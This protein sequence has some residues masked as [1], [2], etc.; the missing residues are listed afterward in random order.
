[1]KIGRKLIIVV[2]AVMTVFTSLVLLQ[3]Y[4]EIE[5]MRTIFNE[6]K[7]TNIANFSQIVE[8]VN[9]KL[10]TYVIESTYWDEMVKAVEC[11]D[12][13]WFEASIGQTVLAANHYNGV[14]IFNSDK[15]AVF[16]TGVEEK[17]FC[18]VFPVPAEMF[19]CLLD[20]KTF[21]HFFI[22]TQKGFMEINGAKY[23]P[24]RP[25]STNNAARLLLAGKLWDTS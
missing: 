20:G 19:D 15:Q 2:L 10:E 14:W 22:Q 24:Q 21:C 4:L 3:R 1:M 17:G 16:S 13:H 6:R 8:M 7:Q 11:K 12:I 25:R 18:S 23:I 5:R 9:K